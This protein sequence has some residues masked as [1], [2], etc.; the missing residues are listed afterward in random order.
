MKRRKPATH[1]TASAGPTPARQAILSR[2]FRST[3]S[4]K[5][6]SSLAIADQET[7]PDAAAPPASTSPPQLPSCLTTD[8]DRNKKKTLENDGPAK[9]K[10]KKKQEKE[11]EGGSSL[12][13]SGNPEPKKCPRTRL[14]LKSL[15]KLKKFCCESALPQ[16]IVPTDLQERFAVLPKC[17]DF[18]DIDL[19][20]A[21]NAASSEDSKTQIQQKGRTLTS[22]SK[23]SNKRTKSIYTPLELQYIEMKQQHKDAILCVEC[24]YKYRF[25]GSDAEIAAQELNIYCHL[26]H[27]FMTASIPTHRLFVHVRRLVAKGYKVGVVKQTETAALKAIGDNRSSVFS[28]KL[29]ALYTKSTLIG[30]DV[31][32]LIK[33]DDAVSVEEITTDTSTNY[34]LCIC[35][36][37][38]TVKDKK[39]G[40]ALI[41]LVAVQPATGEVVFDSFQDSVSRSELETRI[42]C[43]QPVELLLPSD[44]SEQTETLIRRVTAVSVRDDRIRVERMDNMCF[45]YSHA[46]QEIT[47]F[48]AKDSGAIKG[49]QNFSSIMNLEKP[50]ICALAAIIKYLKEFNLEKILYKPKNFKQLSSE[51]EYMTING[52]TLR[53]LEVLQNQTDRKTHG[54]LLWVLDH[55]NT[56]FGRRQL[57]K[58][59]TQ[60]LLKLREINARLDAVSEVL[61]SE[62]SVFGHIENHLRKLPDL[63]R[64]LCSIYHKKCSTQEFFL[65]IKTLYHLNLEFQALIPAVNSHIQSDLLQILLLE[66]P[67]LLRPVEY[68]IKIINEHAAKIGDKT[69]LFKDLSDFPL[70]KKRKDEIQDTTNKIRVHLQEIRRILKNPSAQYVT[71]SG[72]E[73]MIEVKNSALSCIPADWVK[74]GSTKAVSR[75]HSPF[76]VENYRH[77]NQLREQLILDCSAE[78]LDFLE[79]PVS[80]SSSSWQGRSS[81]WCGPGRWG[82]STSTHTADEALS[83]DICQGLCKQ[84]RP[85]RLNVDT[86]CLNEGIDFI[87]RDC[88]LI[89]VQDEGRVD[90]GELRD[91]GHGAILLFFCRPTVQEGRKII[92]K[93]GRHPVIDVLL[94]EQYVCNSTDLSGDAERVMI[95]TGPNMGGKSSYIKQ[96]ALITMMAQI[97]SYVPA[98]E[99]TVGIVDGI[100]TRMG[101]ADNIYKGRSTFMEELTDTA[102]I[103]RKA[104]SQSLV[105]LDE[106]GRGTSTHDGIA[107]AYATLEHF[108]RDVKSLTLFVT[109]YPPVCELENSYSEQVGNYHMGFLVNEDESTQDAGKEEQIPDCVTFL[110]QITRGIA[111]RSYGL[112]VAKLA[113]IPGDILKT[114]ACKSKD[115]EGLVNMKRKRLKYFAKLWTINETVDLQKCADEFTI[116]EITDLSS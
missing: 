103:I 41:G 63:E 79:N 84:S 92:I 38:E 34:L 67:E 27:N 26:D 9:K 87:L 97:G 59:V 64:G 30:E 107:I 80:W 1:S 20:R 112:N 28:R 95:I 85:E 42:L 94:G 22:G 60:P 58:W 24:G 37:K 18:D 78:W 7:D 10:A 74:V 65:I 44:L 90:A 93:N 13:D 82:R 100:F 69:E 36:K 14:V 23:P 50:V 5:S 52:T 113:D 68:Y 11:K 57:K 45:E 6:T 35:E 3:G 66:I 81:S 46:F 12:V 54:S 108:I 72:Q 114:A 109:H 29:T 55:T 47:D 39:Q 43:L 31:N 62:S 40:N 71:V 21:K 86:G 116:E 56:S 106:L 15:E 2:F 61:Q 101:A 89:V 99:A 105:I 33:L 88:H 8:I 49:S 77:L 83:V 53:N 102:E 111:A 17:T 73:F 70:I 16:N 32:P 115:L 19:L 98:E 110:Y 104:T 96:V 75:F 91:G 25:F 48:Y 76:V 4:L 51:M